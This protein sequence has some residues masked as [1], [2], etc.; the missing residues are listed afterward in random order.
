MCQQGTWYHGSPLQLT[1][2]R[3]GSTITQDRHLAEVFSH[4]PQKVSM[5]DDGTIKHSGVQPGLLY[6][7][8]EEVGPG[9]VYPHPNSSM[10]P[11]VEWLTRRELE[12]EL[13]GPVEIVDG[14][15]LTQEELSTL[16]QMVERR[17]EG[18][19]PTIDTGGTE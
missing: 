18:R 5:S 9:D 15:R 12:L 1:V 2:L 7:V 4:K 19:S 16:Q 11:G 3:E 8:A 10:A 14:E 13:I 17:A 6:R